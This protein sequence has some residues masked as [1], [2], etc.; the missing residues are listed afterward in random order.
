MDRKPYAFTMFALCALLVGAGA[1]GCTMSFIEGSG[2]PATEERQVADFDAIEFTG[3]GKVEIVQGR[4]F[5]LTIT[6][7]DN[8]IGLLASEVRDGRLVLWTDTE[9]RESIRPR[10]DI[11][12]QIRLK[13][14]EELEISGAGN[15]SCASL[16]TDELNIRF[17]GAGSIDMD[18][19]VA[20][21]RARFS[22]AGEARLKGRA[23]NQDVKV[24]GACSWMCRDL[25]SRSATIKLSGTGNAE[26]NASDTL[27][28]DISGVGNVS[29]LGDPE[30]TKNVSGFGTVNRLH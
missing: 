28:I 1:A 26:L 18:L 22:G 4:E 9:E 12:Y 21:L 15:F 2:V 10:T 25:K 7:D 17:S 6:A 8:I 27:I 14:L 24:S 11:T 23:E 30:V 3:Q 20:D 29:Y 19:T 13:D 16:K 5:G